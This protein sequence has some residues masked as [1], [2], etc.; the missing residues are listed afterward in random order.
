[1]SNSRIDFALA[2]EYYYGI[3]LTDIIK[4]L[5]FDIPFRFFL[6]L[7]I[8]SLESMPYQAFK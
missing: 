1:M 3:V 6:F 5:A 4:C 7:N 8:L 2:T